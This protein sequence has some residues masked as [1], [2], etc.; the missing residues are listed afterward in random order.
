MKA[1][2]AIMR[3]RFML[4]VQYRVA[5]LA[6]IA[7]QLMFG[8]VFVMILEAF[9]FSS[10]VLQ[11]M[12]LKEAIGYIWIGQAMLGMLPWGG[13]A[14]IQNLI[15]SG[16]VAYELCRPLDLYNHWYARAI[17]LRVAPTVLRALPL[18]LVSL[19]LLPQEYALEI[20]T[21]TAFLAWVLATLGALFLGSAITNLINISMLWTISGEGISRL[22]PAL[23]TVFSGMVVPLPLLPDW[24]QKVLTLLPFAGLVDTPARFFTGQL[25]PSEIWI[26][27]ARQLI[28]TIV[29][30][31]WGRRL[32]QRGLR[33]LVVQGG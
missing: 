18:F 25:A 23:V 1:Y 13:D 29:L 31:I 22:L 26:S 20:P 14:E 2:M 12:S 15:R 21:S 24:S 4:L 17:A 9:Y 27:T 16:N 30:I 5:A 6:G 10:T 28:W 19:F 7:T 32:L 3:V 8:F 11:P 33:R